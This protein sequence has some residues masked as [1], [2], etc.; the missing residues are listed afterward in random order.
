MHRILV[1]DDEPALLE[2]VGRFIQR[3]GFSAETCASAAA[4]AEVF[5]PGR[6]SAAVVDRT[7]PDRDGLECA[8]EW[9]AQDP[10]LRVILCS[11]YSLSDEMV[12][13][14]SRSRVVTLQK[15]FSPSALIE[16]LRALLP[17]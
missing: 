14:E 13:I 6:Y 10:E 12:P 2:L 8:I 17:A 5:T 7:L 1:V 9:L 4:A 11:G 16:S 15:P 3:S